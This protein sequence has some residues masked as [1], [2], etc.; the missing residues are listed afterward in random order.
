MLLSDGVLA[1]HGPRGDVV[2]FFLG[3]GFRCPTRKGVPDFLQEVTSRKDQK[4]FAFCCSSG[5]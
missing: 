5:C 2:P 4:V 1:F 3:M